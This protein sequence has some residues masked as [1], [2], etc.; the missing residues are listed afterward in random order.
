MHKVSNTAFKWRTKLK[1]HKN[2]R[3]IF[4]SPTHEVEVEYFVRELKINT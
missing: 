3:S 2:E 1:N 4:L